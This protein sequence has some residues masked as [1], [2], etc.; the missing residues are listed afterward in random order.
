MKSLPTS[1]PI[2]KEATYKYEG[3]YSYHFYITFDKVQGNLKLRETNECTKCCRSNQFEIMY[4]TGQWT[5][6]YN[7]SVKDN[8][9]VAFAVL[10][11]KPVAIRYAWSRYP[12]CVFTSDK[13]D[14]PAPPFKV[15]FAV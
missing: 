11:E 4:K 10:W 6:I 9:V 13:N 7:K 1:G 12:E 14:L 5:A 2:L 8:Q 15:E 3:S